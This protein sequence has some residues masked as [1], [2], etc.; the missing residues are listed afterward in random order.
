M[1]D[2]WWVIKSSQESLHSFGMS[3]LSEWGG[4]SLLCPAL[5]IQ[6]EAKFD[7]CA[8]RSIGGDGGGSIAWAE[9]AGIDSGSR[10]SLC[11][12]DQSQTAFRELVAAF[13]LLLESRYQRMLYLYG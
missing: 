7:I 12:R 11:E 5:S 9:V 13:S 4:A 1:A 6:R 10:T 2:S 8:G 3:S